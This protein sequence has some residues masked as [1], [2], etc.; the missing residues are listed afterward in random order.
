[1]IYLARQHQAE[2]IV[3]GDDDLLQWSD[4]GPTDPHS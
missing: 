1:V 2:V 3:T 4:Q